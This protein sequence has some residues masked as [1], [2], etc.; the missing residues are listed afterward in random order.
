MEMDRMYVGRGKVRLDG[1][2]GD[3][4]LFVAERSSATATPFHF[5][6]QI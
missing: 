5:V 4:P 1:G 2:G 6:Q 3:A